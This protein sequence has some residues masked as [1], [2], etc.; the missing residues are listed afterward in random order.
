MREIHEIN[1]VLIKCRAGRIDAAGLQMDTSYDYEEAF[2]GALADDD[3]PQDDDEDYDFMNSD[4]IQV[5]V[6]YSLKAKH[7]K[8]TAK[9]ESTRK[10][11][12][13]KQA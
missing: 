13:Q 10:G 11:N 2:R 1:E 9:M 8:K 4:K 7:S 12:A 6:N 3:F 5:R